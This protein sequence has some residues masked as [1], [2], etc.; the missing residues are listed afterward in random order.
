MAQM[1]KNMGRI[2]C[3]DIHQHRVELI[4]KGVEKHGISII[5]AKCMD[6][7]K[8]H[9]LGETFDKVVLDA[10]CSGL[11]VLGQKP[12]L[13]LRIQPEN[14]DEIVALQKQLLDTAAMVC[15]ENGVLVY[16][17]CTLNKKENEKQ[18]ESFLKRH[19]EFTLVS[20]RSYFPYEYDTDGFYMAKLV[21]SGKM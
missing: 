11:G 14:L 20:E 13:K 3:L 16:S 15:K 4:K 7:T 6:A 18:I 5:E 2:V 19:E 10:P 21:K 8:C 12:D 17:T 9:E 1:M